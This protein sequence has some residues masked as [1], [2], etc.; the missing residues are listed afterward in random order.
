MSFEDRLRAQMHAAKDSLPGRSL[1][2]GDTMDR[3]RRSRRRYIATVAFTAAALVAA[4]IGSVLAINSESGPDQGF[5]PAGPGTTVSPEP[6]ETASPEPKVTSSPRGETPTPR[7]VETPP[8][9]ILVSQPSSG[10]RFASGDVIAGTANV[11]EA[12]VSIRLLD[13]DG[14]ELVETFT[15]ATCGSGCRGDYSK[16]IRFQVD[17]EQPGT[18][19]L[20]EV[21]AQDG[22]ETNKVSIPVVLVP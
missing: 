10:T 6:K 8:P 19:E 2:W 16:R 9:P 21:S 3:A 15:T 4:T 18:L 11:F 1:N 14:N 20:F 22:S 12:T 7:S 13:A 5:A 17:R